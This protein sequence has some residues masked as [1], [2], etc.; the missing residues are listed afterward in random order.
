MCAT[1]RSQGNSGGRANE[2]RLSSG[3]NAERPGFER[4]IDKRIIESAYRQQR[5][6]IAGPGRAKLAQESDEIPFRDAKL[7]ML[8]MIRFSP[9]RQGVTVIREPVD[10]LSNA[11]DAHSVNPTTEAGG[12]RNIRTHRDDMSRNVGC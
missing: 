10:S 11:P 3:V 5:E 12:G 4:S 6:T 9:S 8:A 7:D 2:Y 1:L